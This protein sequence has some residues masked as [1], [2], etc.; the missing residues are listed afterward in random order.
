MIRIGTSGYSFFDWKGPVYPSSL[1]NSDF[2][3]YYEQDLGFDIVEVNFT[4]Y[5]LP[6]ARTTAAMSKKVSDSFSFVVRSHK[7]MTHEIWSD[8]K[9]TQLVDNSQV[10]AQFVEGLKPM[11]D[12]GKLICLLLQFPVFFY[13]RSEN[14]TYILKC[15][16]SLEGIPV[17]VE[18]RNKAWITDRTFE[19]LRENGLGFCIVDEPPLPRLVPYRPVTTSDTAYFRFH[20]RN[21]NWFRASREERYNYLYTEEELK[22]FMPDIEKMSKVGMNT[23]VFFNNCHAGA[24]ARNALMMKKFLGL[25]DDY[26]QGQKYALGE[27][28]REPGML[29]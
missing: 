11:T 5:R 17:V 19:F 23:L 15:R 2:L 26:T 1:R 6:N 18:F 12:P 4:Y 22:S 8:S 28:K 9:R 24:A 3:S 20:G 21:M 27:E 7:E 14:E 16:D 10:F 29:F 13:P 25:I